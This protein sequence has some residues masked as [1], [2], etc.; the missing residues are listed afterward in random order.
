MTS[1]LT[2]VAWRQVARHKARS[3]LTIATMAAA[4]AGVWIFVTPN[5]VDA[6]ME[7]LDLAMEE[8]TA[9]AIAVHFAARTLQGQGQMEEANIVFRK[10]YEMNAGEWP[11]DFGMARVYSQEGDFDKALEHARIALER[12]PAG[13]QKQNLEAQIARLEKGENINP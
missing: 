7:T 10:N 6:A 9:T 2:L 3:A 4:V 5:R 1:A 11:V 8:P 12:A 13:A